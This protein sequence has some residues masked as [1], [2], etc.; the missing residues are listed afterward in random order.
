M[1]KEIETPATDDETYHVEM[2]EVGLDLA[3]LKLLRSS[4]DTAIEGIEQTEAKRIADA[5]DAAKSW[6]R[7]EGVT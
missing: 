7:V 3:G 4:I 5:K 1:A 2:V 6:Q